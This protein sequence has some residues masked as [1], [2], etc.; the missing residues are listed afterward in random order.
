MLLET[1]GRHQ[2]QSSQFIEHCVQKLLAEAC[3]MLQ[4]H[5]NKENKQSGLLE[6]SERAHNLHPLLQ[7]AFRKD[8]FLA[9]KAYLNLL[10]CYAGV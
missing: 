10:L 2:R 6:T 7:Y 5:N 4:A 9:D 1:P 8:P 3:G